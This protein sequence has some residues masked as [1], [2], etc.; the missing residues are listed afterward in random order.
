MAR[1]LLQKGKEVKG[2]ILIDSPYPI[3]HEPIPNSIIAYFVNLWSRKDPE[4]GEETRQLMSTQFQANAALL[5]KYKPPATET[6]Y[7]KVII[8]RSRETFDCDRL[9]GIQYPWISDQ[10]ARKAAIIAWEQLIGQSIPVLDI[11]GNHFEA[12]MSQNVSSVQVSES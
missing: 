12:F 3:D 5:G 8:L 10:E 11:P 6:A 2:L 4:E 9:C 1:Q 7:P